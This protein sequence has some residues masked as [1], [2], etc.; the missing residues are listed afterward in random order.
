MTLEE[1][2]DGDIIVDGTNLWKM[3]AGGKEKTA[4]ENI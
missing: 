3:E 4:N 2:S 1:P